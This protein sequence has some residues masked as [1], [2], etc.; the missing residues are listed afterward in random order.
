MASVEIMELQKDFLDKIKLN[1]P[2]AVSF[3]DTLADMLEISIDSVYRRMRGETALTFDEII[4]LC[5]HFKVTF[6]SL[7]ETAY[8]GVTFN[9]NVLP[10]TI[11]GFKLHLKAILEDME[12][13][14]T[15]SNACTYYVA[16]DIPVF[17]LFHFPE[18]AAF[19]MYYWMRSVLNVPEYQEGK[20]S[21]DTFDKEILD[22]GK[23]LVEVYSNIESIEI[24][25]ENTMGS[26]KKQIEYYWEAGFFEDEKD[27]EK[28]CH[29]A[30]ELLQMIN[31]FTNKSSKTGDI[32][33]QN[34][35]LYCSDIEIGNNCI[36]LELED[37]RKVYHT[38]NTFNIMIT[39]DN[40]FCEQTQVWINSIIG[41]STLI[42]GVSEKQRIRFIHK[43]TRQFE[44]TLAGINAS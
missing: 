38:Y 15:K 9:Y 18:L 20:Y 27:A 34:F 16:F 36:L 2:S 21:F 31:H 6:D 29:Q 4:K 5:N 24:W 22:I 42:S 39:S 10:R 40:K 41:K 37:V 35:K 25:T 19:K 13:V 43:L 33:N 32:G 14:K 3:V 28:L 11:E 7:V 30:I 12:L 44:E 23:K 1:I 26:L 17:Y 8:S